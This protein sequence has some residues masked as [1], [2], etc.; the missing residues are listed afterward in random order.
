MSG[1][2]VQLECPDCGE[3]KEV[4]FTDQECRKIFRLYSLISLGTYCKTCKS[5]M[6][7]VN[8]TEVRNQISK[9]RSKGPQ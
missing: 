5:K 8:E 7:I 4:S 9:Y 2:I 1:L 3:K 6:D